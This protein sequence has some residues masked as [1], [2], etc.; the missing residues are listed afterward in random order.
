MTPL[1]S[2][3]RRIL[4]GFM[5]ASLALPIAF[6][7]IAKLLL[8]LCG[9][10]VLLLEWRGTEKESP[11]RSMLMPLAILAAI[12][13]FAASLC[14]TTVTSA[15][16]LGAFAKHGKLIVIPLL[17]SLIRTRREALIALA[18]FGVGQ[19]LLLSSTWLLVLGVPLPWNISKFPGSFA[20]FS[21]Y[22]DQSIM[23]AVLAAVCWHLRTLLP[24]RYTFYTALLVS[25]LALACVFFV[26][27]GRTGHAVGITVVSLAFMWALPKRFRIGIL[28]IPLVLLITLTA[29]SSS[30]RSRLLAVGNEVQAF[31][32]TGENNSPS[33]IRLNL[34]HRSV[35]AIAERPWL[36]YGVGSWS[37]EYERIESKY[38]I[39][40]HLKWTGNPHQEYL[41]W[42]VELG[43]LGMALLGVIFLSIYRDSL[44][45]D[46]RIRQAVQS[47]LAGLIV[48][49][50]FNSILFDALIGDFFC[51]VLGLL[52]ALGVQQNRS[53]QPCAH[54]TSSGH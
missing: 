12:L 32:Q 19:V 27:P 22:L 2:N 44:S 34:W 54:V 40:N 41:L 5:A 49:C 20:V 31:A 28:L 29:S 18:V 35:Q 48:A 36:G 23:A 10:T 24:T 1:L 26:F 51:V 52:L 47:V 6:I 14:W 7:S 38:A 30:V 45:M 11:L 16:A 21:A 50:L 33:G 15:E 13:G 8:L 4:V 9:L 37:Q 53:L 25:G 17:V 42:G 3:F 39:K 43:V 46:Q